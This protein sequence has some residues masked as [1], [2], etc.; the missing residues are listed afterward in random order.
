MITVASTKRNS[1]IIIMIRDEN[2]IE[3]WGSTT[4]LT[5]IKITR[6]EAGMTS[7]VVFYRAL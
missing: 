5:I 2:N 1:S 3:T 4:C 6:A 7:A